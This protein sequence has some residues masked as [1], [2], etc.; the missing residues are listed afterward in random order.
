MRERVETSISNSS[1]QDDL[2]R[3]VTI[4][5]DDGHPSDLRAAELLADLGYAATFYVPARNAERSVI[6]AAGVRKLNETAELGAHTFNHVPLPTHSDNV[7][8]REILDGKAWLED[9]IAAPVTSFC[10]PRGK[11]NRR[12]RNLVAESGFIGARTTL[13]CHVAGPRDSF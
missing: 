11:F 6:A 5:V 12:I 10:Y 1:P 3:L 13:N 2:E 8:R 4:S 7:A 9:V